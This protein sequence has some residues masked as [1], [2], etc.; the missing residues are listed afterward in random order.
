MLPKVSLLGG[1]ASS[2]L[3]RTVMPEG[4]WTFVGSTPYSA[5]FNKHANS[6]TV[7]RLG[8]HKATVLHRRLKRQRV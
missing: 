7:R 5:V 6:H 3:H 4:H 1:A 8:V 2:I